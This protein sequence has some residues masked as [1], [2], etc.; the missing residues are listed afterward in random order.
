MLINSANLMNGTAEPNGLRGFGRVHLEPGMPLRGEGATALFVADSGTTSTSELTLTEYSFDADGS[1]G[2]ELR[3]TLC[4]IDPATAA[5]SAVQLIH[6]LDLAV[7]SPGG[8]RYSMWASGDV[9][10]ANNNERVI[11]PAEDVEADPGTWAVRVWA[12]RL[13]ASSAQSYS[14]VVSGAIG[15]AADGDGA[16]SEVVTSTDVLIAGAASSADASMDSSGGTR[17]ARVVVLIAASAAVGCVVVLA[18]LI[19]ELVG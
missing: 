15:P 5:L 3:A 13:V 11:V 6:D 4:W 1:A 9:D 17:S 10:A 14:L 12:K 8:V 2:L 16:I 7:Y 18:G 19:G